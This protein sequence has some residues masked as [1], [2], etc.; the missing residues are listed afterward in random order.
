MMTSE[1]R[2]AFAHFWQASDSALVAV[3]SRVYVRESYPSKFAISTM[4]CKR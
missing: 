1:V 2:A 4:F 3:T